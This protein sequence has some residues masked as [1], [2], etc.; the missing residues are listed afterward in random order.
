MPPFLGSCDPGTGT[1]SNPTKPNDT[2]P[3]VDG[4]ACTQTDL[5]ESGICFGTN[6]VVCTASDQCHDA[7]SCDPGYGHLLESV[8]AGRHP[9]RRTSTSARW[10]TCAPAASARV[11]HLAICNDGNPCT[12]DGCEPTSTGGCFVVPNDAASCSDGDA[13]TLGD[14][15]VAG[16]CVKGS[17]PLSCDDDQVCTGDQCVTAMNGCFYIDLETPVPTVKRAPTATSAGTAPAIPGRR[18]RATIRMSAP[19]DSCVDAPRGMR[20]HPRQHESCSDNDNCTEPDHCQNGSCTGTDVD[21]V[22]NNDCTID[23]C[24]DQGGGFLCKNDDC[25]GIPGS[26]CPTHCNGVLRQQRDRPG[27]DLRSAE[28]E[29]RSHHRTD[30]VPDRL[31][32]LR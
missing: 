22:D 29:P 21:C 20:V 30:P 8:R 31:H 27:R 1:C 16:T 3:C 32:E 25:A 10:T 13:C 26:D 7:G 9:V 24:D 18:R 28:P 19:D 4:D 15:C 2:P 17:T 23:H 12:T 6:P 14:H 5:C 11:R